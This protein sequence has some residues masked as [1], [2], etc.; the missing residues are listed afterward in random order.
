M[1]KERD[2]LSL[3]KF[4]K[5]FFSIRNISKAI[6]FGLLFLG[7]QYVAMAVWSN[8]QPKLSHVVKSRIESN[9]GTVSSEDSHDSHVT[10]CGPLA[11][12][13]GS[14]GGQK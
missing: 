13:F 7:V 10:N 11:T 12:I 6:V 8:I 5:G 4:L 1:T 2:D 14:C 9:Q 3:S